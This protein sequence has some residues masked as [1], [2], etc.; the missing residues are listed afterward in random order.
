MLASVVRVISRNKSIWVH[1]RIVSLFLK[2]CFQENISSDW[3][4]DW[5]FIEAILMLIILVLTIIVLWRLLFRLL[6]PIPKEFDF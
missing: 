5:R 2:F 6:C 4:L 1:Q 3:Q